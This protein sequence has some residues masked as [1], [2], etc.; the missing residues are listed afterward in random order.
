MKN[1]MS[2]KLNHSNIPSLIYSSDDY[3]Y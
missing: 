1:A 2:E 3:H